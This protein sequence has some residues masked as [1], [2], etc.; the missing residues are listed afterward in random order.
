MFW[1]ATVEVA[2][3]WVHDPLFVNS[4][5]SRP[6]CEP[7]PFQIAWAIS[8]NHTPAAEKVKVTFSV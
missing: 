2:A 5:A 8:A 3:G 6:P 1:A 4:I 7:G